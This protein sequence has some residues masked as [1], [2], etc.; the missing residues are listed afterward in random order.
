MGTGDMDR[1]PW[2]VAEK[3]ILQDAVA[4]GAAVLGICLG[5]QL[6]AEALGARVYRNPHPEIGW[7]PVHKAPEARDDDAAA[8]LPASLAVFHWHGD[9]FDIPS[10]TQRLAFSEACRNQGFYHGRRLIGLQFHLETTPA[11]MEA[12]IAH[13]SDELVDGPY[14]QPAE[15]I[16]AVADRFTPNQAAMQALLEQWAS[17]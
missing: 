6:M 8:F 7:F 3:R 9:T 16:R 2:L 14:I 5:A 12:L 11:G 4:A 13:C 1:F 15:A 10:G 17:A